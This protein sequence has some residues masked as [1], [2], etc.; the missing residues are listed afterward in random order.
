MKILCDTNIFIEYYKNN[1]EVL[2][3]LKEIGASNIAVSVITKAELFYGARNKQELLTIEKHLSLCYCYELDIE[4]SKLF[5]DLI[6]IYALSHRASIP[7]MLIAAT[8]IVHDIPLFTLNVK[9]FRFIP[10]IKLY[11]AE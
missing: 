1:L 9:D 6:K 5:A 7:D 2:Q 3:S 10:A 4:I 11:N 8:A